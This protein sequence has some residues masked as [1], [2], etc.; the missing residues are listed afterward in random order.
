MQGGYTKYPCFL[1][2]WESRSDTKHFEQYEWEPR[3]SFR[4]GYENVIAKPL[5]D[6]TNILLPPLH[7]KLGLMKNFVK[8]MDK[9]S[10]AFLYIQKTF[11]H[12]SDAKLLAGIFDGP[13]IR[14]LI[15]DSEFENTMTQIEKR[16]WTAFKAITCNFLGKRRS[17]DFK[18][19]VRNLL[20]S[21]KELGARMS[22]KLHFLASHLDY[23]PN[24]CSDYS[25]EQGERFHQDIRT[26]EERYQGRWDI[27]MMADY[28]WCLK[29]DESTTS[30]KRKSIKSSFLAN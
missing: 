5:I 4:P 7:I 10:N 26:M 15:K 21:F 1:C 30:H 19:I 17:P 13:Q 24:N 18:D 27:N 14:C 23:F 29:R 12:I 6:R 9:N 8:A 25:E 2:L 20:E 16:A 28:C 3:K 22:V 11:P